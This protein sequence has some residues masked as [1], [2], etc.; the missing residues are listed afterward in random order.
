V[1]LARVDFDKPQPLPGVY[2]NA[3][4]TINGRCGETIVREG[5]TVRVTHEKLAAPGYVLIPWHRVLQCVPLIEEK[6]AAKAKPAKAKPA[7][8]TSAED[9]A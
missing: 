4:M 3:S 7:K 8:A 1:K 6:P 9:L 5:D 2:S